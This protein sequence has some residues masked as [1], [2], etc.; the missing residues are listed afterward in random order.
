MVVCIVRD[1]E[2]DDDLGIEG[3]ALCGGK[4]FGDRESQLIIAW[5]ERAAHR[6]KVADAAVGVGDSGAEHFVA[7]RECDANAVRWFAGSGV[8]HVR[9]QCAHESV[10]STNNFSKRR[11][12]I[13][14]CSS[15]ATRSSTFG[16]LWRRPRASASISSA[17]LPVAHTM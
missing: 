15:A 6:G 1:P 2:S 13:F 9:A 11:R 10:S 5:L 16:E 7:A 4:I 14:R 17:L 3:V 12:V 8:Q